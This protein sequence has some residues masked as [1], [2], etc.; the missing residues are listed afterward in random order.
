MIITIAGWLC[1]ATGAL[2]LWRGTK[3]WR[4]GRRDSLGTPGTVVLAEGGCLVLFGAGGLLDGIWTFLLLPAMVLG[5]IS[6]IYRIRAWR[7]G[8][9]LT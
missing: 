3:L 2:T 5:L 8:R 9:A 4:T 1:I 7:S 6:L